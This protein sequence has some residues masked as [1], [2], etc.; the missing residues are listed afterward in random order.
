MLNNKNS[1]KEVG[2]RIK[3]RLKDLGLRQVDVVDATGASKAAVSTWVNGSS[4]PQ[5]KYLVL[6][7]RLLETTP[8][9]LM[10]GKYHDAMERKNREFFLNQ[11]A[12][13]DDDD[14]DTHYLMELFIDKLQKDEEDTQQRIYDFQQPAED[15]DISDSCYDFNV[16]IYR[17]PICHTNASVLE[18]TNE[19]RSI[20]SEIALMMGAS[21][22]DTFCY[23]IDNDSMKPKIDKNFQCLADGSKKEV[24]DG[25][26]YVFRHGVLLR[27]RYLYN[28][29]DGGLLIRCENKDYADEIVTVNELANIE[30]LGWVYSWIGMATL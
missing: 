22:P 28:Q 19:S 16:H 10:T 1:Q 8:H 6:L 30:I 4:S 15:L 11:L 9:W 14:Y 3:A 5:N 18:K 23:Y 25:Q 2:L 7:S 21:R 13:K 17:K 20:S 24:R 29:P 12:L 26:V 27:T